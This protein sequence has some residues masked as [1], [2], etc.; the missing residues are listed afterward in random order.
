[1]RGQEGLCRKPA[2]WASRPGDRKGL[3]VGKEGLGA[4]WQALAIRRFGREHKSRESEGADSIG[5]FPP[6]FWPTASQEKSHWDNDRRSVV[7]SAHNV[8]GILPWVD[9]HAHASVGMAPG[10]P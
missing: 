4:G 6:S 2:N 7:D 5:V 8:R 10:F 3:G 9:E 1:M